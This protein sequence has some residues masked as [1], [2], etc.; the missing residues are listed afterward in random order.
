M[1]SRKAK[2]GGLP[3]PIDT[4]RHISPSIYQSIKVYYRRY[5]ITFF[6]WDPG[7][8]FC[9]T[10]FDSFGIACNILSNSMSTED[11]PPNDM[12]TTNT[13]QGEL[14]NIAIDNT[15]QFGS[16]N[17]PF[18]D[19]TTPSKLGEFNAQEVVTM[20]DLTSQILSL[21]NHPI[22]VCTPS[23]TNKKLSK[24]TRKLYSQM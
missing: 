23:T 22:L 13:P 9:C 11:I 19:T 24:P 21:S 1:C 14:D 7:I 10:L 12:E 20:S 17:R 2:R 18:I 4:I 6:N 15:S 16:P 5:S 3:V 8:L